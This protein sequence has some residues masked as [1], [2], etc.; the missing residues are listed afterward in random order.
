M[1][2]NRTTWWRLGWLAVLLW[3]AGPSAAEPANRRVTPLPGEG[4]YALLRRHGIEPSPAALEAF[5]QLNQ[6]RLG[7]NRQL[8]LGQTYELPPPPDHPPPAGTRTRYPLFGPKYQWVE[9][10]DTALAQGVF[11]LVSGHGGPDPGAIGLRE[12]HRLMEDEYAYDI[13][14]RL[15]RVLLEHGA[16]VH[17]IIQDPN[18]GIRDTRWLGHDTDERLLGRTPIPANQMARLR[19]RAQAVNNFYEKRPR[20]GLY[21][22]LII[23]HVDSRHEQSRVDVYFYHHAGSALGRRLALT[24]RNTFE[25][26]YKRHQPGRGYRGSVSSRHLY[27][28]HATVP[29]AVFI[30]LGNIRNPRNQYRFIEPA[31]R[32]ALAEWIAEGILRDY[33]QSHPVSLAPKART[34]E[35]TGR[36]TPAG[37]SGSPPREG[38]DSAAQLVEK[39]PE[40]GLT[41]A[42]TPT[43]LT[44]HTGKPDTQ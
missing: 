17:F 9:R 16:T 2:R 23:I 10:K 18:D 38:A 22:R 27:M 20:P 13:I 25:T 35:K 42:P 33:A 1:S 44:A 34:A 40:K 15:G 37:G 12:G 41:P 19:Q 43:K 26:N 29:P 28:L 6:E 14:L 11:Y 31:N 7:P 4:I 39:E 32:Q 5:L 21:H 24:L 3:L 30:E 36:S 8:R